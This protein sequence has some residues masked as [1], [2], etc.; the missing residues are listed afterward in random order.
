M[1]TQT[2]LDLNSQTGSFS[3][4]KRDLITPFLP[5]DL[6]TQTNWWQSYGIPL[7]AITMRGEV[8]YHMKVMERGERD[9]FLRTCLSHVF[10]DLEVYV[11]FHFTDRV[12]TSI[13]FQ[14]KPIKTMSKLKFHRDCYVILQWL[15]EE[16]R[17]HHKFRWKR[18][19]TYRFEHPLYTLAFRVDEASKHWDL[20]VAY[21]SG[22]D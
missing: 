16:C 20:L 6:F 10:P 22:N 8:S 1:W 12:L 11:D 15:N 9:L 19:E 4:E 3:L 18:F 2:L 17:K 5:F 21:R 14:P 7:T 13:R